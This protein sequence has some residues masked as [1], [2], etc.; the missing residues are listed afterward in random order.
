MF[1]LFGLSGEDTSTYDCVEVQTS[2][3]RNATRLKLQYDCLYFG[4]IYSRLP[5]TIKD[6]EYFRLRRRLASE[7]A[8]VASGERPGRSHVSFGEF[9]SLSDNERDAMVK[10]AWSNEAREVI[11]KLQYEALALGLV[12]HYNTLET[13]KAVVKTVVDVNKASAISA[14]KRAIRIAK[15]NLQNGELTLGTDIDLRRFMMMSDNERFCMVSALES[16]RLERAAAEDVR[17]ELDMLRYECVKYGVK[18]PLVS[19]D[20]YMSVSEMKAS[21]VFATAKRLIRRRKKEESEQKFVALPNVTPERFLGVDEQE[22]HKLSVMMGFEGAMLRLMHRHC[23]RCHKVSLYGWP[24][25]KKAVCA[26]CAKQLTTETERDEIIRNAF[27]IWT[28][29]DG[30]IHYELPSELIGLTI[31]EQLLI[32]KASPL[33]PIMHIK[34]GTFGCKGHICTFVQRVN[35]VCRILP[36]LPADCRLVKVIRTHVTTGGT[37]VTKAYTIRR[38]KVLAALRWLKKYNIEYSDIVIDESNLNWMNGQEEAELDGVHVV[39]QTA[40]DVSDEDRGPAENQVFAPE[41][42]AEQFIEA[43]GSVNETDAPFIPQ[44]D[45]DLLDSMKAASNDPHVARMEWPSV[46]PEPISE[47]SDK[48]IFVMAFPWLYPGGKIV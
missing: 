45:A 18:F 15:D 12:V 36:R 22:Q 29:D 35:E 37:E 2:V 19:S 31:A 8:K 6:K 23:T 7:K 44:S 25:D 40:D 27:P 30:T 17:R 11:L 42:Q 14:C 3:L 26:R 39:D 33:I 21:N 4:V 1:G 46:L 41:E 32:Q 24:D 28:D 34:N 48:K 16:G 38:T 47:Y 20:T 5:I 9:C 43:S 13:L 10:E